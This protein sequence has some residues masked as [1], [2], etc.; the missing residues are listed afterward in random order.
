MGVM[1]IALEH[2]QRI[3]SLTPLDDVTH[4]ITGCVASVAPCDLAAEAA[5]GTTLAEDVTVGD[6]RPATPLALIDGWAVLAEQSAHADA[7]APALLTSPREISVGETLAPGAD[8]VAPL[9]A[10]TWRGGA[11]ELST[12]MAPG[13]G[14]LLRGADAEAGEVLW[15]AG[16][17]LRTSDAAAMLALGIRHARVRRPRIRVAAAGR[18]SSDDI[19]DA[20]KTWIVN[21]IGHGGGQPV[22]ANPDTGIEALLGRDG[23]DAVI[24]IGGTGAGAR[25]GS[26]QAL[27][28]TGVVEA[29]GIA[30]SPGETAAFG[31]VGSRPALLLPGRLDAAIA[32]WLLIGQ[33][34]MAQLRGGAEDAPSRES[35]L[36]AKAASTVGLT[37]LVL[38][39]RAGG[40]V[41]PL[42]SRYLPPAALAH[43]DGWIVIPAASEGLAPGAPVAVRPLP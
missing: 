33:P 1:N 17:R 42:A 29:H 24:V 35:V 40:G 30:I 23:A 34:L 13:D 22:T 6:P 38:V 25:D 11:G 41:A 4:W 21:A 37:E 31:I 18:G 5:P 36:T 32:A 16:H 7:Y 14:V 15:R 12:P 28:R 39:R 9:D 20:I 19:L 3:A 10:V 8:A 26:V 43:A 2:R 27:R